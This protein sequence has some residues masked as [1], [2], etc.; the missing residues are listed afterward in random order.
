M[1]P[2]S[3]HRWGKK[4]CPQAIPPLSFCTWH[5][6]SER[7]SIF[8]LRADSPCKGSAVRLQVL[9]SDETALTGTTPI[10][11]SAHLCLSARCAINQRPAKPLSNGSPDC[12]GIA[13]QI[14]MESLSRSSWNRCPVA[15]GIR[16][17]RKCS[18]T[19][20]SVPSRG[21]S[22]GALSARGRHS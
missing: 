14:L 3:E 1:W 13:V 9:V 19:A 16:S 20:G 7:F 10:V 22:A 11:R 6:F 12:R 8:T 15:R 17:P 4:A 5:D 2:R 21:F 18:P